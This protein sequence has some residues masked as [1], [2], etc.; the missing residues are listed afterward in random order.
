VHLYRGSEQPSHV[1]LFLSGDGGWNLGVIDMAHEIAARDALVVGIDVPH[2]LAQVESSADPCAYPAGELEMLSQWVQQRAGRAS[3]AVPVLVGYSSGAT[4]AYAALVQAPTNTFRGALSLGFCPSLELAKPLCQGQGLESDPLPGHK[5]RALRP[6]A[7]LATPWVALQGT[8]DQ[9]CDARATEAYVRAVGHGEI[10]L[11]P[12]HWAPELRAAFGKLAGR[13]M[14]A[15]APRAAGVSDLPLVE[16][17]SAAPG[18]RFAVIVSGDGGWA[19]LD[20]QIGETLAGQGMPV[21]GLDAL[22]YFWSRKSPDQAGADLARIVTHYLEAWRKQKVVLIGYSRGADVVPF[23]ASRLR[24]ELRDRV[25][26]VAL[27][28]PGLRVEFE[29]HVM[30]W[31]RDPAR[32]TSLEIRPEAEKLRG[33]R[34]L[35]IYGKAE[36]ESLCRVLE[37]A[38]A[39]SVERPGAHHFDGDYQWL[40]RRILQELDAKR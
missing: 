14:P 39:V 8:V 7:Q 28:G 11:L 13:A 5:G 24:P 19:S 10:V 20:R 23:M 29:F 32:G 26:L 21:V 2:Y 36:E 3:Y 6:A 4:L 40:A 17:P 16:V 12:R 1:A 27:L 30:D 38:L 9:V 33:L 34:V 22:Q 18:D 15:D 37:P 25:E 35:C 31:L